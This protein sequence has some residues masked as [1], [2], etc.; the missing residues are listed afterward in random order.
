VTRKPKPA[1]RAIVFD[2]WGTLVPFPAGCMDGILEQIAGLLDTPYPDLAQLWDETW[3]E[4]ATSDLVSY[5]RGICARLGLRPTPE[6]LDR[7]LKIRADAHSQLFVPRSDAPPTLTCLRSLGIRTAVVSNTSS[8][9]PPLWH[10]S[11]LAGMI[12]VQVFSCTEGLMKPDRRIF[13]LVTRRLGVVPNECLYVG[14]GADDE[15]D[16]ARAVGMEALLLR[17]GDTNPPHHW[18]G[19]ELVSLSEVLTLLD[20]EL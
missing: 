5:L 10:S 16:G 18:S 12:D 14:D 1:K 15:L 13:E 19:P 9:V 3:P 11:P 7:V 17:P 4:R 6:Q 20:S 8:E 2:L